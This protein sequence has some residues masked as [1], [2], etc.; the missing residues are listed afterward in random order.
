MK[1]LNLESQFTRVSDEQARWLMESVGY[2]T[3]A[4]A[5]IDSVYF[6]N[7]ERFVLSEEVV[8]GDDD[9]LYL[10]IEH[11]DDLAIVQV[12]ESGRETIIESVMFDD[13]DFLLTGVYE[14][15]DGLI[16]AKMVSESYGDDDEDDEEEEA[17]EAEEA[18]E[19][20][21]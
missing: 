16:Y 14:D 11:I 1:Y 18:E 10:R 8:E 9:S 4:P 3:E 13:E 20:E 15:E 19:K 2:S 7:S 17:D 21:E 5:T 6:Y 12:D